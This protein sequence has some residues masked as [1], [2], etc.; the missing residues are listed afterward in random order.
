MIKPL[1]IYKEVESKINGINTNSQIPPDTNQV[2]VQTLN[3]SSKKI[4]K[5]LKTLQEEI[6]ELE[7]NSEWKQYTISFIGET[8]AGK[9][10]IIEALRIKYQERQKQEEHRINAKLEKKK[11]VIKDFLNEQKIKFNNEK[12]QIL[13]EKNDELNTYL[14]KAED[15]KSTFPYKIR[16]FFQ[17][18]FKPYNTEILALESEISTEQNKIFEDLDFISSELDRLKAIDTEMKYDGEIIGD[19]TLDFTQKNS[20]FHLKINNELVKIIDVPG[21]EGNEKKYETEIRKAV[22]ESHCVFY[23]TNASKPLE[24]GTLRKVKKYIKDQAEIYAIVNLRLNRYK[25]EYALQTFEKI[26]EN[27]L[28]KIPSIAKQFTTELKGNYIDTIALNAHWG[29]LSLAQYLQ[30]QKLQSDEVKLLKVLKTPENIFEKSNLTILGNIFTELIK[31]KE[32]KIRE[33]NI[34]KINTRINTLIVSLQNIHDQYFNKQHLSDIQDEV[35]NTKRALRASYSDFKHK[36]DSIRYRSLALYKGNSANKIHEF[37]NKHDFNLELYKDNVSE[38]L[39]EQNT[40]LNR[41]VSEDIT[42]AGTKLQHDINKAIE[43]L[44]DR[45]DQL[46]TLNNFEMENNG[47]DLDIDFTMEDLKKAGGFLQS[48]ASMALLGT[49][50]PGIG[51]AIGALIGGILGLLLEI[52]KLFLSTKS[53]KSKFLFKVDEELSNIQ[54]EHNRV[55]T[56]NLDKIAKEVKD[57]LIYKSSQLV[58]EIFNLYQIRSNQLTN[59]IK[60]LKAIQIN[61]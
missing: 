21:I 1:E 61:K 12:E 49:I 41:T 5:E 6:K 10:T 24:E 29:F 32:N 35:N 60:E 50:F 44:L 56:D 16:V 14:Q 4:Q 3:D 42:D 38:I 51:N 27:N 23:V 36:L 33:T 59:V 25:P 48:I 30:N 58:E 11:K 2:I 40:I 46:S 54:K 57:N 47:L 13:L 37:V 7:H 20:Y 55:L 39:K 9:S 45:A 19:G 43:K 15:A 53:K 31:Q 34:L 22:S 17:K 28:T 18:N 52:G 26:Y 8:N